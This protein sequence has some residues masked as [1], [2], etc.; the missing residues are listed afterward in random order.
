MIL[1][2]EDVE[3]LRRGLMV[4]LGETRREY[5]K[6]THKIVDGG[7]LKVRKEALEK[8]IGDLESDLKKLGSRYVIVSSDS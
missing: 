6:I 7:S 8:Q 4:K 1:P 5:Q 3:E 2:D